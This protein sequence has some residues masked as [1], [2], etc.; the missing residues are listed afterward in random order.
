[1]ATVWLAVAYLATVAG[2]SVIAACFWPEES[3][4]SVIG[5]VAIAV[6]GP[7]ILWYTW[8]TRRLRLESHDQ[9]AVSRKQADIAR[10]MFEATHRPF[11]EI[12]FFTA[13]FFEKPEFHHISYKLINHGH[14]PA[15]VSSCQAVVTRNGAPSMQL[16]RGRMVLF[17]SEHR[18]VHEHGGETGMIDD[19]A[20][21]VVVTVSVKYTGAHAET[22]NETRLIANGRIRHWEIL[23]EVT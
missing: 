2:L 20:A 22:P 21:S 1:L 12:R 8:E 4:A 16:G 18:E 5:N 13:S 17:P 14:V 19:D 15:I 9:V 7:I 11:V 3:R 6:T 10:Q 23:D